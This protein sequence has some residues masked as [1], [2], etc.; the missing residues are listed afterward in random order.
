[1]RRAEAPAPTGSSTTGMP[2]RLA[3][4]PLFTIAS[5]LRGLS[6]PRFSTSARQAAV[7]SAPS[8]GT[9]AMMGLA[10]AASSTLAQSLMVTLL[11]MQ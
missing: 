11:V 6:I 9:S 8:S 4:W 7:I 10:P 3:W 2:I 5:S 1:M